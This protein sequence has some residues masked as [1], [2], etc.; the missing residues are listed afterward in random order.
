[1]PILQQD[2][3]AQATQVA[4]ERIANIRTVLYIYMYNIKSLLRFYFLGQGVWPR[5]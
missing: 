4:E 3:L 1:M 5:E 2:S